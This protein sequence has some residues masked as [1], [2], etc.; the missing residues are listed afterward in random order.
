MTKEEIIQE[1]IFKALKGKI[2]TPGELKTLK[3]EFAKKYQ[4]N[5]LSNVSILQEYQKLLKSQKISPNKK[6]FN[7]LKKRAIRTLS[8]VAPVAVLTK[9]YPCP[10]RCIYCPSEKGM[11]KSYLSNEPAVRRAILNKFDP[12]NQIRM[13]LKALQKIGHET[14]KVELIIMGGTWSFFPKR[15][16][17]WFIKRCFDGLNGRRAKSFKEAQKINEGVK[18]RCVGLTLETRPDF[19]NIEEIKRMRSL[20][21]TR[22]EIGVQSIYPKI[23]KFNKR[24]HGVKKTIQATRLLKEAG[25]KVA[26]HLMPNLPGSTPLKDFKMFQEI[27]KNPDFKPDMIKIYPCV[28]TEDSK[29]YNW[30][31]KKKYKPY[32]NK[33]LVEL[34]IK[35][36]KII[37]YYVRIIRLIR[38]IPQESIIAGNKISNLRQIL[39]GELKRRKWQCN[40]IRCREAR[41]QKVDLKKARLFQEKYQASGGIEYFLSHESPDRKILYAFLRL[42][43]PTILKEKHFLPILQDAALIRELHT[44]GE[45]VPLKKQKIIGHKIQHLGFGKQLMQKA[46]EIIK[47]LHFKKI[48][49]ISGIG[50]RDYYRKLGYQLEDEYMVKYL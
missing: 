23:L 8:G 48:A 15:Y 11:P 38:D 30:W 17:T 4:I 5:I 39:Q 50:V 26:Y 3:R 40:C 21:A 9:P 25:F 12:H 34:L 42:R 2:Q 14:D 27:F 29:L 46:E 7:L 36:K 19:I 10:G 13:R 43:I 18:N 49:V 1:L 44:Y 16:Q 37:P 35:I 33:Q 24:G 41:G 22:V 28:L 20:G 6:L 31:K 45:L 47:K 32:S